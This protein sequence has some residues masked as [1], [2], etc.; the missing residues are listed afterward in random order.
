MLSKPIRTVLQWQIVATAALALVAGILAGAHGASS[1][2]L[3]GVVSVFAGWVSAMA[4]GSGKGNSAGGVLITALMAE[5]IKIGLI[6]ILMVVVLA[7][8]DE[9]VMPAFFGAFFLTIL[10][11]SMAFFVREYK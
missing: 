10:L 4:A 9:I 2:V 1:A 11:F 7:T 6:V 8:Y 3:G 5:G